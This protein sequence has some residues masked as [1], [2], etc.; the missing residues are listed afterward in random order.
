MT[1]QQTLSSRPYSRSTPRWARRARGLGEDI[2]YVV[3]G[4][5]DVPK[6]RPKVLLGIGACLLTWSKGPPEVVDRVLLLLGS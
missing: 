1:D 5:S 2:A 3:D 6:P 4:W